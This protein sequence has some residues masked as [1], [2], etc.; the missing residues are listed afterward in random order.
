MFDLKKTALC[1]HCVGEEL[2]S[3]VLNSIYYKSYMAAYKIIVLEGYY[4]CLEYNTDES[5]K[6]AFRPSQTRF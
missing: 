2:V 1:R 3:L 4:I 6:V 5:L